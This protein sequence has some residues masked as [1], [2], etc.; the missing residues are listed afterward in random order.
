M[1]KTEN[2][3]AKCKL[4]KNVVITSRAQKSIRF[5]PF[6]SAASP[7]LFKNTQTHAHTAKKIRPTERLLSIC[8]ARWRSGHWMRNSLFYR[9][10]HQKERSLL[11]ICRPRWFSPLNLFCISASLSLLSFCFLECHHISLFNFLSISISLTVLLFTSFGFRSTYLLVFSPHS[12]VHCST[13]LQ[14]WW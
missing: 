14:K 13:P 12:Y 4:Y 9:N 5:S 8:V 2:V 7:S 1:K 11:F 3:N 10:A 6:L